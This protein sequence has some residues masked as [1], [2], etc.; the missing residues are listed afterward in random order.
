MRALQP[1]FLV[2]G[3]LA[4]AGRLRGLRTYSGQCTPPRRKNTNDRP[5]F[6]PHVE[7]SDRRVFRGTTR[8]LSVVSD[9]LQSYVIQHGAAPAHVHTV[10]RN[11][12]DTTRFTPFRVSTELRQSLGIERD[13][14]VIG[15]SGSLKPWHGVDLLLDAFAHL[16]A[17]NSK[18]RLLIVGNGPQRDALVTRT[19]ELGITESVVFTGSVP[20]HQMASMLATMDAGVAPYLDVPNFYFSPLKIYEYMATGLPIVAS[21]AG[22]I[23]TM[24]QHGE[25]GLLCSPGNR[26][27]LIEQLTRVIS[28]RAL[29]ARLGSQARG[30]V[31]QHSW[32]R[33]AQT[34]IDLVHAEQRGH[35]TPTSAPEPQEIR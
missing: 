19:S 18:L 11:G 7:I 34:V 10:L 12:V 33:N 8:Q 22:E 35:V 2:S 20:H 14:F 9:A 3:G 21:N 23:S 28:D 30:S 1:S 17:R 6:A 15:F 4:L 26:T 25:T 16:R 5:Y 24:V 32:D 13:A 27:E 31:E 29:A